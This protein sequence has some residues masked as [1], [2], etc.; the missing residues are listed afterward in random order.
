MF[1]DREN[2]KNSPLRGLKIE[3]KKIVAHLFPFLAK[4]TPNIACLRPKN[5]AAKTYSKYEEN[6]FFDPENGQNHNIRGPKFHVTFLSWRL[7]IDISN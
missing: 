3:K 2:G 1:F 5:N 4:K 6:R 7:H